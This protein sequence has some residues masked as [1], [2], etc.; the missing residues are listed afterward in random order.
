MDSVSRTVATQVAAA[1]L[2]VE[3]AYRTV[4]SEGHYD[5]ASLLGAVVRQL[6]AIHEMVSYEALE[7]EEAHASQLRMA[8]IDWQTEQEIPPPPF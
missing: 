2:V 1:H 3:Q 5:A 8:L 6:K 7:E 4:L